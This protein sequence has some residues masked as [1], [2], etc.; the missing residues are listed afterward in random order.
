[1]AQAELAS[2]TFPMIGSISEYSRENGPII[3]PIA[4]ASING[5]ADCGPLSSSWEYFCNIADARFKAVLARDPNATGD[6][7]SP[8]EL[9]KLGHFIYRDLVQNSSLFRSPCAPSASAAAVNDPSPGFPFN[10]MDLGIQNILVSTT[11]SNPSSSRN[12]S[13]DFL[14]V[15]DWE[16]AQSAPWEVFCYTVPFPLLSSQQESSILRDEKHPEYDKTVK[17]QKARELYCKKFREAEQ[18]LEAEGRPL[19]MSIADVLE[20]SRA[21]RC[22]GAVEKLGVFEGMEGE[23]VRELVRMGYAEEGKETGKGEVEGWLKVKRGRWRLSSRRVGWVRVRI[24]LER[25][26]SYVG[27]CITIAHWA[28]RF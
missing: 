18:K 21:S 20:G 8:Y 19:P 23:L 6:P 22:F 10:H 24:A 26:L 14:A 25:H 1:M 17:K 9:H 2:F 5:F 16:M 3:D 15:I 12:S 28:I 7:N 27:H 4:T 11:S 13:Y